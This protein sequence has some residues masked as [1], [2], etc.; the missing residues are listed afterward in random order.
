MI[1]LPKTSP[2]VYVSSIL[3]LNIPSPD[4]TGDWHPD[5]WECIEN[6]EKISLWIFGEGQKFDTNIL[7]GDLGVINGT[8]RLN[9]MGYYP[10]NSPVW[11]ADHSRAFVDMLSITT[12]KSGNLRT[13]ILDDWFP[14]I[15][16]KKKVYEILDI[17]EKKLNNREIETLLQWKKKNPITE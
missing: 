2:Q 9:A 11:I 6:N 10:D 13:L 14:S 15:D 12:L 7:L 16:D 4:N 17:L 1:Y 8:S 5:I 3:A